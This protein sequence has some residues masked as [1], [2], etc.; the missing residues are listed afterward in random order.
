MKTIFLIIST[1][2]LTLSCSNGTENKSINLT[3]SKRIEGKYPSD[4]NAKVSLIDTMLNPFANGL[5]FSMRDCENEK[6][7][8]RISDSKSRFIPEL[9]IAINHAVTDGR[10]SFCQGC[11]FISKH[12]LIG[13]IFQIIIAAQFFTDN[14]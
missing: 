14:K 2:L 4:L 7:D 13:G 3:E 9:V 8:K 12:D 10:K 5:L 11:I 1:V 6:S